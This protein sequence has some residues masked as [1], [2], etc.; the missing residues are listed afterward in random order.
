MLLYEHKYVDILVIL[1]S[2]SVMIKHDTLYN[3][4]KPLLPP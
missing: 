4:L 2:R 3:N 1:F